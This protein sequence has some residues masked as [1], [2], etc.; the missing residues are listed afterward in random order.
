MDEAKRLKY[1]FIFREVSRK[2]A[3]KK[4]KARFEEEEE[5]QTREDGGKRKRKVI[6]I[7]R[8]IK[9]MFMPSVVF[10]HSLCFS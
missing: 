5:P 6:F 8:E 7:A 3:K 9:F 2:A 10:T 1:D 4:A